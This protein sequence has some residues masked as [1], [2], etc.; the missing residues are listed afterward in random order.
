MKNKDYFWGGFGYLIGLIN[1]SF[2]FSESTIAFFFS[3]WIQGAVILAWIAS[4]VLAIRYRSHDLGDLAWMWLPGLF[5]LPPHYLL[6][7]VPKSFHF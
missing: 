4:L 5:I 1:F 6:H 7:T 2:L 3:W